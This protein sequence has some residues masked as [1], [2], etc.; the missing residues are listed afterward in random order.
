MLQ[1]TI[2]WLFQNCR[3]TKNKVNRCAKDIFEQCYDGDWVTFKKVPHNVRMRLFNRFRV[4]Y[5]L[6]KYIWNRGDDELIYDTFINVLKRRFRDIMRNLRQKSKKR[7]LLRGIKYLLVNTILMSNVDFHQMGYL[8]RSGNECVV[9]GTLQNGKKSLKPGK[10]TAKMT[11]A[12]I[13]EG[14]GRGKKVGYGKVFFQTHATKECKKWVQDWE[15]YENDFENLD[16]VTKR[17]KNSYVAYT[18]QLKKI[19]PEETKCNDLAIWE[20]LN[21]KRKG[22]NLFR[23]GTSDPHFV[24]TGTPSSTTYASYDDARHSQEVSSLL[25]FF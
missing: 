17:A 15:I 13:R 18:Q 5:Q 20:S 21:R 19:Y 16:F 2:I 25:L 1:N 3:F 22:G 12:F 14:K 10:T 7:I 6:T 9:S 23:V 24:V 8:L 4:A 11:Y